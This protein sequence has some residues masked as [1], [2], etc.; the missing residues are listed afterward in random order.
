MRSLW[1]AHGRAE[2][3]HA[4]TFLGGVI[5]ALLAPLLGARLVY[6][7]EGLYPEEMVDGGAWPAGSLRHR[8][9]RWIEDAVYRRADGVIVL[10]SPA[11]REVE[12]RLALAG[13]AT[14]VVVV[15]SVVD[16][17]RFRV[18]PSGERTPE[19]RLVYTGSIGYRYV[20]D[21]AAHFVAIA[22]QQLGNVRLR[23]LTRSDPETVRRILNQSG[24]PESAWS[25]KQVPYDRMPAE[26]V[27]ADAGLCF[28]T[29]AGSATSSG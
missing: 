4:R 12:A 17:E 14:P 10:A 29:Q 21:R 13:R 24:L 1:A 19:V 9:T 2:V 15:P 22:R 26:L 7:A 18:A 6:H 16:L 27:Q 23:V 25:M 11:K 3:V 20:F 8:L 28:G 5:G